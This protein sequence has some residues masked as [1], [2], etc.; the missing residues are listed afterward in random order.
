MDLFYFL[1]LSGS[2]LALDNHQTF[3]DEYYETIHTN[4]QHLGLDTNKIFPYELF[5]DHCKQNAAACMC[6]A[7]FLLQHVVMHED[8]TTSFVELA[9]DGH[10]FEKF[11]SQEKYSDEYNSRVRDII[12][13]M[14]EQEY[15]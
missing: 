1:F 13:M 10:I 12:F 9:N 2:R 15:I 14:V 7:M 8:E 11:M 5:Q 4:L 6:M 3:L